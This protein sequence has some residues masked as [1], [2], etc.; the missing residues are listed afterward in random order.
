M[1]KRRRSC[2]DQS[3]LDLARCKVLC[4]VLFGARAPEAYQQLAGSDLGPFVLHLIEL[5][6]NEA[7]P[8]AEALDALW[9]LP[10]GRA[11]A[12]LALSPERVAVLTGQRRGGGLCGPEIHA[13]SA[14]LPGGGVLGAVASARGRGAED[15]SACFR[16]CRALLEQGLAKLVSPG[17][18]ALSQIS[19]KPMKPLMAKAVEFIAANY[20]RSVTLDEIARNAY[21][22]PCHISRMFVR[23][24]GVSW[25]C[26]L[27]QLRIREAI[28]LLKETNLPV[29][30]VSERVGIADAHYFAKYFKK[31]TGVSPSDY[32]K[33]TME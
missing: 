13:G 25:V 33:K 8:L 26:Y 5:D 6:A 19:E 24:M 2:S 4:D 3:V 20:R 30:D 22:S 21:V 17:V 31:Q 1:P 15:L 12:V 29:G 7:P 32:R 11:G 14:W 27:W 28:K 10:L 16:A 9:A 23:E 18:N